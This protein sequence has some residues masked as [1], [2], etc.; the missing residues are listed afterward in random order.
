MSISLN[1]GNVLPE[2]GHFSVRE[3]YNFLTIHNPYSA[4]QHT[5]YISWIFL[6]THNRQ[7]LSGTFIGF[8]SAYCF[9]LVKMKP[10]S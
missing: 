9:R 1:K 2:E 7:E 3:N 4:S 8:V 10:R 5:V 6:A